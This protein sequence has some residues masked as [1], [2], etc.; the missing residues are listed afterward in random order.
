MG[1]SRFRDDVDFNMRSAASEEVR[2]YSIKRNICY[3]YGSVR[4]NSDFEEE[5]TEAII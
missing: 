1:A 3:G 2:Q 4:L 5:L